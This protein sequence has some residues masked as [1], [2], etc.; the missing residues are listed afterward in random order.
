M[1]K[2]ALGLVATLMF[3][4]AAPTR[5]LA[6]GIGG[7]LDLPF[8]IR[9]FVFGAVLIVVASWV[10]LGL[11][12]PE[13]RLQDG[14]RYEGPGRRVSARPILPILGVSSLLLVIGQIVPDILGL[15]RDSTRPT[16]APV[17]V[18]VVF[19]LVVPFASSLIGSWYT[20]INPWRT[21]A[22][23][24]QTDKSQI[25]KRFGVWPAAIIFIAFTWFELVSP[26]SGDPTTLGVAALVYTT[27]LLVVMV[28]FGRETGLSFDAF[29]SYNRLF[30]AISPVGRNGEGRLIWRGWLRSLTVI[31]EWSGLWVFVV[32]MIG[33]IS[34]DGASDTNWFDDITFGLVRSTG[35]QTVLL[36][37][38]VVVVGLGYWLISLVVAKL[39]DTGVTA[40][41][42]AQRFAHTLV[43]IALAYAVAHYFT[44]IIFEGQQLVAA[45]SDPFGLG[46]D[47]FGTADRRVEF[48]I[49]TGEPIW[50]F[51]LASIVGGTVLGVALAH[52]RAL[53]DF[54]DDA[55]RPRY[56]MLLMM[57]AL[58]ALG[59]T[60][61]AG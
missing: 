11:L 14:P 16:I 39:T 3:V 54:G 56:A 43:P 23:R 20:D 61:L 31:P 35:G 17:M 6:H 34:Y 24:S 45:I 47:L 52:D 32:A 28:L 19:W 42:V 9:Y 51:Q 18:W 12:W 26:N 53:A 38:A 37:L 7:G 36:I 57:V 60:I 5:V 41:H 58:T 8:S 33:T 59:L 22:G 4:V 55:T 49:A 50:Y 13:P 40:I 44:L 30:S 1:Y 48:F 29:T 27:F 10:A 21:V 25:L 46:W 2:M 15:E